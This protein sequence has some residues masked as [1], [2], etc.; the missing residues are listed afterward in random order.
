MNIRENLI[1]ININNK[2]KRQ[3]ATEKYN[4]IFLK[5][6]C[7]KNNNKSGGN[8]ENYEKNYFPISGLHN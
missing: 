7:L 3:F 1:I 6:N 4:Y 2:K 8:V 5:V